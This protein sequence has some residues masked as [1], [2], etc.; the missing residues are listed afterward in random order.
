MVRLI[1][2]N[3]DHLLEE[4]E[5]L[6]VDATRK[7]H[8]KRRTELGQFFTPLPTARLMAS[9]FDASSPYIN[10]LDAGAGVGS[11]TAAFVAEIC[12]RPQRPEEV[13][14]TAYEIDPALG[15]Y[16]S[17]TFEACRAACQAVDIR[18]VGTIQQED[19]IEACVPM[20]RGSMFAPRPEA[21][22][23]A[24]LNPPYRKI[25]SESRT[26]HLLRS[27]GVETSNLY[28]AFLSVVAEL[29]GDAGEIVTITPRSFCNGPYFRPFRTRFLD[30]MALQQ[31]HIFDTR[32]VAFSDDAVLQENLIVH[33]TK[34]TRVPSQV[35]ISSSAGPEDEII[36]LR[37]VEYYQLVKPDDPNFFIRIT[38]DEVGH[39]VAQQMG[40]FTATLDELGLSVSTGR[41]VDFRSEPYLRADPA[42][43]TVPLIYPMHIRNSAI[44][45]PKPQSRKP[46]AI[47]RGPY[48]EE[49]F[50][51]SETYVLVKRFSAKEERRRIVAAIYDPSLLPGDRVGFENH[52]N[53]YHRAGRG[54][55]VDLARGL[56]AFLNSTL[57]DAFF[58]QFN[59][60]TQV[61]A[62]DLR[63]LS[64]PTQAQLEALGNRIP[65]TFPEQDDLDCLIEEE[66][67]QMQEDGGP[68]PVRVKKRIDETIAILR[69][70][71]LPRAQQNERSALALLALLDLKADAPWSDATSPLRGITPMMGFFSEH[72]GRRY[73][74]NTRE[75]VRRQT[76]HQ[77]V[78]AGFVH[79]NPDDANRPVNSGKTVY[80][81]DAA[82]LDVV[83]AYATPEWDKRLGTYLASAE[84]LKQRYAQERAMQRIPITLGPGMTIT[85]SPGGQNVLV[86]KIMHEFCARF[87]PGAR[88]IYI[89]DTDDKWAYFDGDLLA[90]LGVTI[91]PH[92]KMPDV[93]VYSAEKGWLVVI[94]AVTSHGPVNPKRRDELTRLLTGS[95]AGLVFVTAFLS[96]QAMGRYLDDISWETE[97][98]VAEV[99][100]HMIHFNGERFLGP[101]QPS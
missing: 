65:A 95:T 30:R 81:I 69:D 46:N 26:R 44:D 48:T 3:V 49:L 82:L 77:F 86:E 38:P 66:L 64:Y 43:D 71:G 91:E 60:H 19:F 89:G 92:G 41:V 59:G 40:R 54:L 45:W 75:T 16:L 73:A 55:P 33:A 78:D 53:Y 99:P 72:Y 57:V 37:E 96:L 100:T 14:V 63:S 21:F 83:R 24:I 98:W 15:P 28:T 13:R 58:R 42:A 4:I 5:F 17:G 6:R 32:D 101:S 80:Q 9:M 27:I 76:V 94:E 74:P 12:H 68:N 61:N 36:T 7:L 84:T 23:C 67:L 79:T 39:Q 31:I 50:L 51:P 93:V 90:S 70:L 11:L 88:V 87:T 29:L 8:P 62:T 22:T 35:L 34:E 56:A 20:L 25:H 52:L 10:L 97:V 18:F 1:E 47:T 85:L 2:H